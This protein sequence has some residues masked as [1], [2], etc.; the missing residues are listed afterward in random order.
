MSILMPS[1]PMQRLYWSIVEAPGVRAGPLPPGLWPLLEDDVPLDAS[2]LWAVGAPIDKRNLLVC[3]ALKSELALLQV[4]Q[5]GTVTPEQ[6]PPWA[7]F[8]VDPST[9]NLLVGPFEPVSI[10]TRRHKRRLIHAS[11]ALVTALLVSLGLERRARVWCEESRL[12]DA[13]AQSV[14]A[15]VSPSLGWSKDDLA[16][17]LLERTQAGPVTVRT[18]GDAALAV[19]GLIGRWPAHIPSKAQT[20][21][22]GGESAS[23][24]VLVPGDAAEFI[25]ALKPPE[26]WRLDEPRLVSVD[27]ATRVNIELRKASP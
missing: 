5:D 3:A 23:A 1:I 15:S 9:F 7:E 2:L 26:G 18:A 6:V 14:L 24:T 4:T 11:L 27:K 12:L 13:E 19:A 20:I 17:E 16:L 21:S 10:R 25:A 22:A 8:S